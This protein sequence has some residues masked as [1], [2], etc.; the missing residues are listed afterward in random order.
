[1]NNRMKTK[2][3]TST[4]F[5]LALGLGVAFGINYVFAGPPAAYPSCPTTTPG[6]N[7]PVN[8]G[9]YDQVKTAGLSVNTF[10]A[11]AGA[12]F[13]QGVQFDQLINPSNTDG[14]DSNVCVN[15]QAGTLK[16]CGS[17]TQIYA[18]TGYYPTSG[19]PAPGFNLG[20]AELISNAGFFIF[21]S[22]SL[23]DTTYTASNYAN[24]SPL[25]YSSFTKL[26]TGH[27]QVI[28]K[29]KATPG[30]PSRNLQFGDIL[31]ATVASNANGANGPLK[32]SLVPT[33][34]D[35]EFYISDDST[36]NDL[37]NN[38]TIR[39]IYSTSLALQ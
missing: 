2:K 38:D 8:T 30:N 3:F 25:T 35:I 21:D 7:P 19:T 28:I 16:S 5:A 11:N 15:G 34:G 13:V 31:S 23:L 6:C 24:R 14:H 27:Y 22:Q 29:T 26:G 1:M 20:I 10:L 4:V 9:P 12:R 37:N 39:F 36:P 33:V 18:Q 32:I 17:N